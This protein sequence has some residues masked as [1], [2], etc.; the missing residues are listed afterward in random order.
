MIVSGKTILSIRERQCSNFYYRLPT[1]SAEEAETRGFN[2]HLENKCNHPINCAIHFKD[3]NGQWVT[4]AWY[5]FDP[6]E[7]YYLASNGDRLLTND[8]VYYFYAETTDGSQIS[9]AADDNYYWIGL[10]KYGMRKAE[11]ASGETELS[12]TCN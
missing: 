4:E 9:W 10:V 12:L 2:I 11:D 7:S 1:D 3:L 5:H 8:S 6:Y